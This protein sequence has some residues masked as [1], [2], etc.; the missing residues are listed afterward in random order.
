MDLLP[1]LARAVLIII[2]STM[3]LVSINPF[4]LKKM[5]LLVAA[6]LGLSSAICFADPLFMSTRFAFRDHQSHRSSLTIPFAAG[7]TEQPS[8]ASA[9]DI[10]RDSTIHWAACRSE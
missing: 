10:L 8:F 4:A 3:I 1:I 9:K 5:F 2:I 6:L 7:K